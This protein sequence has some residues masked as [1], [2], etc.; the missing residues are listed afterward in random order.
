M[1]LKLAELL[2][3]L[4]NLEKCEKV[5]RQPL[6]EDPNP[7]GRRKFSDPCYLFSQ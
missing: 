2:L 4:G 7:I 3:K 6:D 1:R 5:L